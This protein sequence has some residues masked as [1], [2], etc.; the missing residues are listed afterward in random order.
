[1][2]RSPAII[3]KGLGMYETECLEI[4]KEKYA[5]LRL[6]DATEPE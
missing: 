5:T 3:D 6:V 4:C 2:R 1:M